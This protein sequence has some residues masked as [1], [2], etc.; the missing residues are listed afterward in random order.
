VYI[1]GLVFL[2]F[3][4]SFF[5]PHTTSCIIFPPLPTNTRSRHHTFSPSGQPTTC[6]PFFRFFCLLHP[7]VPDR[8]PSTQL[9]SLLHLRSRSDATASLFQQ[10]PPSALLPTLLPPGN[11]TCLSFTRSPA[12]SQTLIEGPQYMSHPIM[13]DNG[14]G[15]MYNL[16]ENMA[17]SAGE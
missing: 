17:N 11:I 6:L 15:N 12:L 14:L 7:E 10:Q 13:C 1:R 2:L 8:R 3:C 16:R 4:L 5:P 9:R